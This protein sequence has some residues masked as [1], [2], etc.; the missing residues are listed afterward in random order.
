MN[1]S[2]QTVTRSRYWIRF[3]W[4]L[5][6]VL[7][8]L[9]GLWSIRH[10]VAMMFRSP[11]DPSLRGEPG[12]LYWLGQAVT[13]LVAYV[14]VAGVMLATERFVIRWLAP[15]PHRGCANCGYPTAS[16]AGPCA[17]CGF[18]AAE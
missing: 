13:T 15:N 5:V 9:W 12:V 2:M 11:F 18:N 16:R 14:L 7:I 3:V 4:R 10:D 6:V 17:E 8:L 1:P